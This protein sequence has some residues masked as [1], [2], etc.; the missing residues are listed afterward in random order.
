MCSCHRNMGVYQVLHIHPWIGCYFDVCV[1]GPGGFW[2]MD[3][4]FRIN[5]RQLVAEKG[6]FMKRVDHQP[7]L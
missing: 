3:E 5:P 2:A 1:A 7:Q 6:R 4:H